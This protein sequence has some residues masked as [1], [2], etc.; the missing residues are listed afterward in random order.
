MTQELIIVGTPNSREGD[1]LF[2]AFTKIN[3][4]FTELYTTTYIPAVAGDW[5]GTAPTTV[6]VALDRLAAAVK[7]LNTTGA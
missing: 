5:A 3:E 1:S 2:A 7:V 4:N 6:G